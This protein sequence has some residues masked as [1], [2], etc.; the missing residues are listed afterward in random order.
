MHSSA[1][2]TQKQAVHTAAAELMARPRRL[3]P[4]ALELGWLHP[5]HPGADTQE[6]SR[7]RGSDSQ[8]GGEVPVSAGGCLRPVSEAFRETHS[9]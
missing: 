3:H 8:T 7:Q 5:A 4:K 1:L 2:G 6:S 9:S